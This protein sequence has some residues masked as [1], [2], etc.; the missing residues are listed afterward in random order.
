MRSPLSSVRSAALLA[1][2]LAVSVYA[3]SLLNGFAYDDARIILDNTGLH[4]LETLPRAVF[5]PYWHGN[6]GDLAL[7]LWRPTTTLL[8]GLEYAVVGE[9]P[10][11]YHAVNVVGHGLV[12]LLVVLVLAHL[13]PVPL[14]FVAGLLFAVHPVHVE[15]VSNVVGGAEVV[16]AGFFLF[17]LLLHLR[18][19]PSW[20]RALVVAAF[21]GLAFGAKEGAVTLPGVIFLVDAAR[22]RLGFA[23]LSG[24]VRERWRTYAALAFVAAL[25]L[26]VRAQILGSVADPDVAPGAGLLLEIPRI[27]TL[28]EVWTHYVRLM[29]FP[30]DLASDYT[31]AVIPISTGFHALNTIGLVL[32]LLILTG[33]LVSWRQPKMDSGSASARVFGFGVVWFVI[34]VSP[35]SHVFFVAGVLLGE[36]TLYLPSVGA[37]AVLAWLLLSVVPRREVALAACALVVALMGWRSWTRTPTWFD[38]STVFETLIADYPHSGRSQW[39]MG[40]IYMAQARQSEA[41]RAYREAISNLGASPSLT[42]DIGRNLLA[43]G[44]VRGAEGLL[45]QAWREAPD[46]ASAP[47][48]LGVAYSRLGDPERAEQ[49]LVAALELQP[50]NGVSHHLMSWALSEQGRWA[51]AAEAR[52]R[53]IELG[54]DVWQQWTWLADLLARSGDPDAA[55]AAVQSARERAGTDEERA[56]VEAFAVQLTDSLAAAGG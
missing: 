37:V 2:A 39:L 3:N 49:A 38:D 9:E 4:S 50:G 19:P 51:E 6:E 35:V 56:Q 22:R 24:Y 41:L 26:G 25:M 48:L 13:V 40:D 8:L 11:L 36:R 55:L 54:E 34:T 28:A 14:A 1:G 45:R 27:W 53:V 18:G 32:A 30:L 44:N 23:D 42:T 47:A 29:V 33:A 12:T 31:P 15:A 10:M 5:S 52:R 21:Y 17:A 16:A 43:A 7:G 20:S 46:D